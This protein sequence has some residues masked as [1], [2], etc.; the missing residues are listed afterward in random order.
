MRIVTIFVR[1][2]TK[3]YPGAEEELNGIFS[4]RLGGVDRYTVVVDNALP[5]DFV[6]ETGHR[7]VLGG[8]NRMHE[9]SGF[10]RGISFLGSRIWDFDLVN[11][12]TSAFK[13]LYTA[14]L[15][16]F[17]M[18]L[19]REIEGR[20]VCLG[21]VDC[22]NEPVDILTHQSQHWVRTSFVVLPPA[23]VKALGSLVSVSDRASFFTGDATRPFRDDAPLSQVYRRYIQ[24]WLNGGDIGQGVSWHSSFALTAETLPAFEKKTLAILNEHLLAIRL[25]AQGCRLVDVTWL[26][27]VH[28]SRSGDQMEWSPNWKRQLAER[29]EDRVVIA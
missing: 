18:N 3:D 29:T 8:D 2:G 28:G 22:Y 26:A 1:F 13:M 21:H 12:A 7:V 19:L 16:R 25:R 17:D 20:P 24:E 23:E 10:D 14:Y 5:R 9:F 6:E 4:R 27:G 15:D 11:L